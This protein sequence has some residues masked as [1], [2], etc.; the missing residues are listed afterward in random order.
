MNGLMRTLPFPALPQV[1]VNHSD[2]V[3]TQAYPHRHGHPH[4]QEVQEEEALARTTTSELHPP[5]NS[6]PGLPTML[7]AFIG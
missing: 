4:R 6:P 1:Q 5:V 2:A 3:P 7:H